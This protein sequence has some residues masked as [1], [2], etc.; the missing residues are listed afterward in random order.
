MWAISNDEVERLS[1][2]SESEGIE[3]PLLLDPNAETI[4]RYGVYNAGD[5]RGREIP[6]PTAL[7]VDKN[8]TI[9][10]LRVDE[11]YPVR[12]SIDELLQALAELQRP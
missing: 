4:R 1:G 12:P 6:H 7:I 9:R 3:V 2:W 5:P 11:D 10:Y 8:G